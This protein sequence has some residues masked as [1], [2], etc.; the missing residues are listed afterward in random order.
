MTRAS[1]SLITLLAFAAS[2]AP[3]LDLPPPPDVEPGLQAFRNPTAEV[4]ADIMQTV[5]DVIEETRDDIE[6]SEFFR[7]VFDLVVDV[8]EELENAT[9]NGNLDIG[10]GVAFPSPN[11]GVSVDFT[12]PGW[13]NAADPDPAD[14]SI[15]L[16]LTLAGGSI[17][18]L[19]WGEVVECRRV[20][21]VGHARKASADPPGRRQPTGH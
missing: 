9:E 11:G 13:D 16:T 8:Q 5:A 10:G 18:P 17:G 2:C 6:A 12:C 3:T 7:E 21:L 19:V 20:L 15:F 14:G 4:T 1:L